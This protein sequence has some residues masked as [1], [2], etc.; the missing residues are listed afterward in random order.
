MRQSKRAALLPLFL[1]TIAVSLPMIPTAEAA[2]PGW[3]E[4]LQA[5]DEAL[6]R[7]DA[8]A[9]QAAWRE[10]YAMAHASH[11]WPGMI[12][13]GD[14][15]LRLGRATGTAAVSES[16]ARRVYLTALLRARRERSLDGV[17]TAGEAFG[18]LGDRDVVQQAAAIAADLAA[19]SGDDLARRRVQAF[20]SQ[21]VAGP[22]T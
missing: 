7:G 8:V 18:R 13:V 16:R 19:R 22:L 1:L 6:G 21:W 9:A 17:L 11:G 4:Q 20:R 10:A 2:G 5:M 15:A 12:V 14:A 3:A